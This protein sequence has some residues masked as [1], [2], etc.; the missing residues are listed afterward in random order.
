MTVV[1]VIGLLRDRK[2]FVP[3]LN[4]AEVEAIFDAPLEMFLKDEK[5]REEEKE[6]NGD[7]YVLH[8]F[9]FEFKG[10]KKFVIWALTAGILIEVASIAFQRPPAF[11]EN[12]P[13]FWKAS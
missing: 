4:P 8:F 5:R 9:D 1:P 10:D 11:I 3:A 12:H 2:A 6:W 7:K 13:K